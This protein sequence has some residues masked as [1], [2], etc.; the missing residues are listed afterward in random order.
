MLVSEAIR[1]AVEKSYPREAPNFDLTKALGQENLPLNPDEQDILSELLNQCNAAVFEDPAVMN[2]WRES[3]E[4]PENIEKVLR[5]FDNDQFPH[6]KNSLPQKE[7]LINEALRFAVENRAV[8][9]P[10]VLDFSK[11]FAEENLNLSIDE[12]NMLTELLQT[13]DSTILRDSNA[14]LIWEKSQ[15]LPPKVEDILTKFNDDRFPH[16]KSLSPAQK[17]MLVDEALHFAFEVNY[18]LA[19]DLLNLS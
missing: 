9:L 11:A 18:H 15:L 12:R 10:P 5:Q 17:N 4:L 19:K 7:R 16:L 14:I 2:M 13:C 1:F 6:L 8:E 3:K